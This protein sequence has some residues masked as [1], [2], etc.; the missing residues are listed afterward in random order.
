MAISNMWETAALAELLECKGILTRKEVL[1]MIQDR[2]IVRC[3]APIEAATVFATV[4]VRSFP[5]HLLPI[6][7]NEGLKRR[8]VVGIGGC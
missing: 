2:A 8:E 4:P 3:E 6:E 5:R 1:A 7:M